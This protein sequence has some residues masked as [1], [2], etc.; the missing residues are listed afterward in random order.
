MTP[1]PAP[2]TTT[3]AVARVILTLRVQD[4]GDPKV[5]DLLKAQLLAAIDAFIC[6]WDGAEFSPDHPVDLERI[7]FT[8]AA[9]RER[10]A[11]RQDGKGDDVYQ[12]Q[13]S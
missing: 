10:R 13:L 6:E 3:P 4:H 12:D 9:W 11:P 2:E 5:R 7:A 1:C 8:W